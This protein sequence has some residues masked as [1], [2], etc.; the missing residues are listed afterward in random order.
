M[1]ILYFSISYIP[2]TLSRKNNDFRLHSLHVKSGY[3]IL[4]GGAGG[5]AKPRVG[6]DS[7]HTAH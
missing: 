7:P 4:E 1:L 3:L 2:A 6:S 5:W